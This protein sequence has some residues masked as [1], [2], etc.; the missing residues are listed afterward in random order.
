MNSTCCAQH[1]WLRWPIPSFWRTR[2]RVK[3]DVNPKPGEE[4]SSLIHKAYSAPKDVIERMKQ[5]L[6]R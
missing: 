6:G 5:A 1:S 4:V 2:R 3:L